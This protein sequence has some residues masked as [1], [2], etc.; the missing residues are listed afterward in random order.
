MDFSRQ[1]YWSGVSFPPPRD[2]PNPGIKLLHRRRILYRLSHRGSPSDLVSHPKS[3][4]R[5]LPG[6]EPASLSPPALAGGFS[7]ALPP[8]KPT[9]R[10]ISLVPS[11]LLAQPHLPIICP[12][13]LSTHT[14][15]TWAGPVSRGMQ[16]PHDWA[17]SHVPPPV[18]S[19]KTQIWCHPSPTQLNTPVV[20]C[21]P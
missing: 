9:R 18:H 1:E 2:L 14:T 3:I 17:C 6:T 8:G 20:P 4:L 15:T 21:C 11:P 12:R 19:P 5:P 13:S 10:L 7:T 16:P